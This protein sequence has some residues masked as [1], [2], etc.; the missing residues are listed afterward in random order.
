MRFSVADRTWAFGLD[1]RSRVR[2]VWLSMTYTGTKKLTW[3]LSI[4]I[5]K[6]THGVNIAYHSEDDVRPRRLIV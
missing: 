3:S 5:I 1:K 2:L 6:F 4:V